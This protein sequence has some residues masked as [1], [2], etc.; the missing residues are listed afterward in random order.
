M[1]LEVSLSQKLS[2]QLKLAPQIIQSIEILQLPALS[3]QELIETAL[4]ENEA[5]ER[6]DDRPED[7]APAP[8]RDNGQQT[9]AEKELEAV[10]DTLERLEKLEA[11]ADRDWQDF[12]RRR[13]PA[14]G[15][16][17]KLEAMNNTAADHTSLH[18]QVHDQFVLLDP[19]DGSLD[20][21]TFLQLARA[22]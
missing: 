4:G 12:G 18:E 1:R 13:A 10:A 8:E 22:E 20:D 21:G 7:A 19:D 16:D 3:L 17:P 15:E 11:A 9:E 2:L 5:L 14:G 6:A